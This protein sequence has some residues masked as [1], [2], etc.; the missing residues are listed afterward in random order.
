MELGMDAGMCKMLYASICCY[1]H[2][3]ISRAEPIR[4]LEQVKAM[5]PL[6]DPTSTLSF[7]Q[8][9]LSS[10]RDEIDDETTL[11]GFVGSPWT[12]AAYAIEGK[13]ERH[14]MNTKVLS[15]FGESRSM[16]FSWFGC[17]NSIL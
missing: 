2:P 1:R 11:L 4:S 14:C 17:I 15:S 10:L 9:T 16:R 5:R 6:D 7:I 3:T 13:A 12:L 8:E